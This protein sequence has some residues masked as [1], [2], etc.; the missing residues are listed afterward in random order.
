M[1][2]CACGTAAAA[3][4]CS[5]L[6]AYASGVPVATTACTF[7]VITVRLSCLSAG[8]ERPFLSPANAAKF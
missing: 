2:A 4:P 6:V 8:S 7:R 5:R 3:S 1:G